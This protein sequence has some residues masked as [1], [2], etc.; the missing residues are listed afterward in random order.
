[1]HI[2]VA[3]NAFKNS[4]SAW[5]AAEAIRRGLLQSGLPCRIRCFPIG[6]GGDGTA[7]LIINNFKGTIYEVQAK[8]PIGRKIKT[9]IGFIDDGKTAVIEMADISGLKLL[10]Q[11]ETDPLHASSFG[12]G[13]LIRIAL[14]KGASKIILGIGGSA[15]V[16]GGCGILQAL[17]IR[18]LDQSGKELFDL[19]KSLVHLD[20]IDESG[21]DKRI[22]NTEL[23]VLCDV[24]NF[25]LGEKGAAAVFG[26]QKGAST[27]AIIVLEKALHQ[28]KDISLLHTGKDMNA[29]RHGGAAG[30]SAAG[31]KIL[32]R[33][34]LV[35][36]IEYFLEMTGFDEA[37]QKA[38]LLITGEGSID[39]QTMEGK[40]PFGVAIRAKKKNIP[41]I[42]L[43]G[44]V[45][46]ETDSR[47][48]HYF[49]VL[50]AIGHQPEDIK[51]AMQHT[52]VSLQNT[53]LQIGKLISFRSIANHGGKSI[54]E[55]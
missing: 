8:D 23:I 35:Q 19:P 22:W 6:D 30:G 47:F 14:D 51:S 21:I 53:A 48:S 34:K 13:E 11:G 9:S 33:A 3:P 43:A 1:M 24:D 26:P 55:Q 50:M 17:G 28:L 7:S 18:F 38:D 36:G 52:A 16:D 49:D 37:L 40:G 15:T 32:L 20:K 4:L 45:P 31:L 25:L 46:M 41:V 10:Q 54:A 12:T 39:L 42:G 27:N 29:V 5:D 2:L 44:Q